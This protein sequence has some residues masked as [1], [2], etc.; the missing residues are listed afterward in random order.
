[1]RKLMLTNVTEKY[2]YIHSHAALVQ[3]TLVLTFFVGVQDGGLKNVL[4]PGLE[5]W[6]DRESREVLSV[7]LASWNNEQSQIQN[8]A[9]W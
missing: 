5:S 7:E 2:V 4:L 6:R 3:R 9:H 8:N 1:M